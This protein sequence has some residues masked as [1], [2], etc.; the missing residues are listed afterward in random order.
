MKEFLKNIPGQIASTYT[1]MLVVFFI[2][3]KKMGIS[4]VPLNRLMELFLV[5]VIGGILMEAAFGKCLIRRMSDKKRICLFLVPFAGIT[6]ICAALFGWVTEFDMLDTYVRF[7][8]VFLVCGVVSLI[9][10]EVEHQ[11]R[12]REYTRKLKEYQ[13]GGKADE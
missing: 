7:I 9:I 11:I 12:G 8:G 10:F 5:A 1:I 4:Q 13:K 6:F 2:I 3:N